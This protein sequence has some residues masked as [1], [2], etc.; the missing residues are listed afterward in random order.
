MAPKGVVLRVALLRELWTFKRWDLA[1]GHWGIEGD[2]RPWSFSLF[3]VATY[4]EWFCSA[5]CSRHDV[6]PHH[7]PK[8]AGPTKH[9]LGPLKL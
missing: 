4:D 8:A 6:L 2:N 9:G 5:M 1:G 7:R 3:S